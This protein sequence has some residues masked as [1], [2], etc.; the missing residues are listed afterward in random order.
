MSF[1]YN[2][3]Y[4]RWGRIVPWFPYIPFS[5]VSLLA[6]FHSSHPIVTMDRVWIA[7][8]NPKMKTYIS[9]RLKPHEY[10]T[11]ERMIRFTK[12]KLALSPTSKVFLYCVR[13]IL[14][15][16]ILVPSLTSS[17]AQ[18]CPRFHQEKSERAKYHSKTA[19]RASSYFNS[20]HKR[21]CGWISG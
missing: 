7:I 20:Y 2:A 17:E 15:G 11:E 12:T 13:I 16:F 4:L 10:L 1:G 3:L 18:Q 6:D 5:T 8:W 9:H 14:L 21:K 19:R